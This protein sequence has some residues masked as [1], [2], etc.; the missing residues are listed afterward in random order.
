LKPQE[1]PGNVW[2]KLRVIYAGVFVGFG[3]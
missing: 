3:A 1:L 2:E